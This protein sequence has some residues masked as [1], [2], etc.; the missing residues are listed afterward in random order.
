MMHIEIKRAP[1]FFYIRFAFFMFVAF[2]LKLQFLSIVP[3]NFRQMGNIL[4]LQRM[5]TIFAD[6]T[7]NFFC[8]HRGVIFGI[9]KIRLKPLFI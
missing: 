6:V 3:D 9:S 2:Y 5:V 7:P 1:F 8:I 4:K